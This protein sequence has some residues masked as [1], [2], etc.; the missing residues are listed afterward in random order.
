MTISTVISSTYFEYRKEVFKQLKK[1]NEKRIWKVLELAHH[2]GYT[3]G[4]QFITSINSAS[5]VLEVKGHMATFFDFI[6]PVEAYIHLTGDS[7]LKLMQKNTFETNEECSYLP[8]SSNSIDLELGRFVIGSSRDE[9]DPQIL[10]HGESVNTLLEHEEITQ[11]RQQWRISCHGIFQAVWQG[12]EVWH[13]VLEKAFS[14]VSDYNFSDTGTDLISDLI[15]K[16]KSRGFLYDSYFME[17]MIGTNDKLIV[18]NFASSIMLF[19]PAAEIYEIL[20]LSLVMEVGK[21]TKPHEPKR[22]KIS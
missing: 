4:H 14:Q 7:I 20:D 12:C 15:I 22:L 1:G 16:A 10:Q 17:K 21:Y 2:R 3:Y 11:R 8:L 9:Y 13:F 19:V 18:D 6:S 5:N